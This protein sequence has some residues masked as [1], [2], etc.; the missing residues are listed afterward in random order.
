MGKAKLAELYEATELIACNKE[1]AERILEVGLPAQ[2]GETD[3][4]ELLEKMHAL[5]PKI[6]L[7][8]DGVNGAYASDGTEI[9][10]IGM[11][12][13]AKPPLD[14]TGAGDASTSTVVVAIILGKPL[15]EALAWGPVNSMSVVQEI[16]AQKGLLTRD[17]LEKYLAEAPD[18]YRVESL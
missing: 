6:V 16:G 2:A 14:R 15:R 9:L 11:Y 4:K 18:S 13:D 17:A 12:P 10:K 3:I 1:E 8:T 5:G 7:I